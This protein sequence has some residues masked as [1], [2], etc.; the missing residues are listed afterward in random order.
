MKDKNKR[1]KTKIITGFGLTAAL[2]AGVLMFCFSKNGVATE[3]SIEDLR[4]VISVLDAVNYNEKG[5][6]AFTSD[7]NDSDTVV[8]YSFKDMSYSK[9]QLDGL[10]RN[11]YGYYSIY[12]IGDLFYIVHIVPEYSSGSIVSYL[13]DVAPSVWTFDADTMKGTKHSLPIDYYLHGITAYSES[14]RGPESIIIKAYDR[15]DEKVCMLQIELDDWSITETEMSSYEVAD[16]VLETINGDL[17]SSLMKSLDGDGYLYKYCAYRDETTHRY[18]E[19]ILYRHQ[20][21][22][23]NEPNVVID[24]LFPDE[25]WAG[26]VFTFI[27]N[28]GNVYY[29]G[30]NDIN[31]EQA[32]FIGDMETGTVRMINRC[33]LEDESPWIV[34]GATSSKLILCEKNRQPLGQVIDPEMIALVDVTDY[35]T[36]AY[37]PAFFKGD[38]LTPKGDMNC[39]STSEFRMMI[40]H[41]SAVAPWLQTEKEQMSGSTGFIC[42]YIDNAGNSYMRL[43]SI[44]DEEEVILN[45]FNPPQAPFFGDCITNDRYIYLFIQDNGQDTNRSSLTVYSRNGEPVDKVL[46]VN[47]EHFFSPSGIVFDALTEDILFVTIVRDNSGEQYYLCQYDSFEHLIY[48]TDYVSSTPIVIV[49]CGEGNIVIHTGYDLLDMKYTS[50]QIINL[51]EFINGGNPK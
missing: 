38:C 4:Q 29:H 46:L 48:R 20:P 10:N 14:S 2:I 19:H 39:S 15:T 5:L 32:D 51:K 50:T 45:M 31:D 16:E 43:K 11:Y 18:G 41:M 25:Y 17:E 47:D 40:E 26:T 30:I 37:N 49:G 24:S 22:A 33:S 13:E 23:Q 44:S 21:G 35:C 27:I 7:Q 34:Y 3:Q 1:L 28:G 36:G 12:S 9:V 6:L 42:R 8:Y